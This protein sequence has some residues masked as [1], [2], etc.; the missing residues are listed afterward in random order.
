MRAATNPGGL[1]H[2]W[3]RRRFVSTPDAA[4]PFVPALV[5]D[6]PS[7]DADEYLA[8]LAELDATTRAQLEHGVWVRDAEGL[9]YR[10]D[11]ERNAIGTAPVCTRTLLG[12]DFGVTDDCAFVILGWRENDPN[13]YVLGAWKRENMIPSEAAAEVKKLEAEHR[14]IRIVGDVGGLGKAFAEEARRRFHLPIE[15]AEKQNK[16]GYISLLNGDLERGRVKVVRDAGTELITE[17]CE[18]PW[19]EGREKEV[20]GFDNHCADAMLYAWRAANAFT[21]REPDDGPPLP[22]EVDT[23]RKHDESKAR[24]LEGLKK[25]RAREQRFGRVPPT[26]RRQH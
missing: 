26:H 7:L 12:L 3:V 18:L 13:V 14:F 8:S 16:R 22:P 25:Q 5:V 23:Q 1:G 2:E 19:D 11:D 15:P 24:F 9:V 20:D 4:R 21:Q 6:N 10:F 17:W